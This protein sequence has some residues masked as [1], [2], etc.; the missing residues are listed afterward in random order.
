[1]AVKAE[2][3]DSPE[4]VLFISVI[5]LVADYLEGARELGTAR[6]FYRSNCFSIFS[7]NDIRSVTAEPRDEVSSTMEV[8]VSVVQL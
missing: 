1:M 8:F 7:H 4:S 6:H 2:L 5:S 3:A